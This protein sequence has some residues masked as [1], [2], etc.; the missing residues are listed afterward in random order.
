M[1]FQQALSGLNAADKNL[2]VIGNNVSNSN[3]VGFKSSTAL[4]SDVF[5]SSLSGGVGSQIG[6]GTNVASVAENLSQG[7]VTTTNNAL[8]LAINGQGFFRV[9]NNGTIS[10]S[11][12]GQFKLDK[13]GFIVNNNGQNLTGYSAVNGAVV[14]GTVAN[15]KIP[16]TNF[17]PKATSSA[18]IGANLSS[19][20]TL[21]T[22]APFN[23]V[24]PNTYNFSTPQT[25][26]DSLGQS[27]SAMFYFVKSATPNVWNSYTYV[28]GAFADPAQTAAT[29]A[30]SAQTTA[31]AS[32]LAAGATA[33]QA[34]AVSTAAAT[35]GALLG[36]T[37]AS[38]ALAASTAV[39]VP[40]LTAAQAAAISAAVSALPA[41]GVGVPST[42]SFSTGG[43]LVPPATN[44][45]KTI[46]LTNGAAPLA[47]TVDFSQMT[48]YGVN[49]APNVLSQNGYTSGQL[50]GYSIGAD[51]TLTGKYSNG[52]TQALGQV[53]L[54]NFINSQGL[55]P[56]GNNQFAESSASGSPLIAAP[57]S[58]SFGT[59][60]SAAVEASN[61]DLTAE[62]VS[63]I[64]AQRAYQANAQ[65]IKTQ[66]QMMQ[67]IVSL[68]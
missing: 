40:V 17:A 2:Q 21:P 26:Y 49:S 38:I 25:I 13:N 42:L 50:N 18:V 57:G 62:L 52:Q 14:A 35:A 24:D 44:L 31:Q 48:Q 6:I 36:A 27:H 19:A 68:R 33:A 3:T 37:P 63:M 60:Q 46:A 51:G 30:T 8:D 53:I 28:D 34:T 64:T 65:T 23:A 29:L 66:D 15:L 32:A 5:A 45:N 61:V 43:A 59:I 58:S 54:A 55:Q 39:T 20:S 56:L 47:F 4:F 67:T 10:Y 7:N 11:R 9:S 16:T 41:V 1:G 12:N 22:V